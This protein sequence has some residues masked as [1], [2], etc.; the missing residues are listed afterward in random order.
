[1]ETWLRFLD[2]PLR[3]KMAALLVAAS[4]LLATAVDRFAHLPGIVRASF[5]KQPAVGKEHQPH[6]R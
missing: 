3:A 6:A 4:V 5:L 2:W 1:M